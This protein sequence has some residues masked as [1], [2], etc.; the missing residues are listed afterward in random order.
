MSRHGIRLPEPDPEG[1]MI[2]P[3]SGYRYKEGRDGVLKCLDMDEEKPLPEDKAKAR[4]QY[5]SFKK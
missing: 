5:D 1:I 3:E 2:C 4:G